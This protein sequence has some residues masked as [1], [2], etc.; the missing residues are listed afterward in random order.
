MIAGSIEELDENSQFVRLKNSFPKHDVYAKLEGLNC[1]F[2]KT[3]DG[4]CTRR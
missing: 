3:Q 1:W 4:Y 2:R